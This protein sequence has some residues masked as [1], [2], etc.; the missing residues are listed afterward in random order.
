[1]PLLAGTCASGRKTTPFGPTAGRFAGSGK[2][3]PRQGPVD[4]SQSVPYTGGAG[5][6]LNAQ[7]LGL[8]ATGNKWKNGSKQNRGRSSSAFAGLHPTVMPSSGKPAR[9]KTSLYCARLIESY[10]EGCGLLIAASPLAAVLTTM[11]RLHVCPVYFRYP[12]PRSTQVA[13]PPSQSDFG[14]QPGAKIKHL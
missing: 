4:G 1:M 6:A 3:P 8:Q 5:G 12:L 7:L 10:C 14:S 9:H 2:L 11:E 13:N